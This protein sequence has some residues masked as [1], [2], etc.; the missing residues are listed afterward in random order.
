MLCWL[1]SDTVVEITIHKKE[2]VLSVGFSLP[3]NGLKTFEMSEVIFYFLS[4][5]EM[6]SKPSSLLMFPPLKST[7]RCLLLRRGKDKFFMLQ[8]VMIN[9]PFKLL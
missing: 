6:G 3:P 8:Y 4:S 9:Y 7:E 1:D 2:L 5:S